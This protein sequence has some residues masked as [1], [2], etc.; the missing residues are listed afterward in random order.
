MEK[1][2][3]CFSLKT[4]QRILGGFLIISVAVFVCVG[5]FIQYQDLSET[6]RL[7][8]ETT[9]YIQAE[10]KKFDNYTRGSSAH[11]LQGML[12]TA[13]GLKKFI[14]EDKLADSS[15]LKDFIH[16]EHVGGIIV[17]DSN[18][19]VLAQADMDDQD[20]FAL[21]GETIATNGIGDI[22]QHPEETY[23]DNIAVN[24]MPYDV[25]ATASEDGSI[26][27]FCYS[28][29]AK[30]AYDPYE[31]TIKSVLTNNSFFK[32][33]TLIITDGT[34]ILSTNDT[35]IEEQGAEQYQ[36]MLSSIDW[37]ENQLTKFRYNNTT[38]Y[39]L[40]RVYNTYFAYT[41]Y[42]SENVFTSR[43]GFIT[44]GFSVYML[45]AIA[46]LAVQRHFDKMSMNK[47]EKQLRI[48]NAI[49]TAYSSTF[50]LHVDTMELE[51]V[52]PSDRLKA[53]FERKPKPY[54][55][56]FEICKNEVE[57]DYYSTV[58]HFLDLDTIAE[59]LRGKPFLG[60]EVKDRCG[61][62]YSVLLIPQKCDEAG[63]I[64]ALL[65][66]T[67]DVTSVKQTEELTFK[68]QLTGLYN[69]NYME[70][71]SKNF[72][73]AGDFPVS[74][75]MADCNYLKRTNDTLGHEYGDLLLQRIANAITETIP[76]DF[77]AMRV[78]GDEFLVLCTHCTA[79]RAQQTVAAIKQ[80]L[81]ERSDD[82]LTLSA[83]FGVSTTENGDE[84]SFDQAYEAADQEMY[85]DK[86]AS[87]IER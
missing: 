71:R 79:E 53:I 52:H 31:L 72:V 6:Y 74:L 46:I 5:V 34:N 20:S 87:R 70:S 56:L 33:P 12:D 35:A 4:M 73:R 85:R 47:M 58:M 3:K 26:L 49:S 24:E 76:D 16:T 18:R 39:G 11:T 37:K 62:W 28:S 21:W 57:E 40:R 43:T 80:K 8:K 29:T 64:Q 1:I 61:A 50:L 84:F 83:A 78:G 86:K 7:A 23:I 19:K 68:D 59:R 67:R 81:A 55:F 38:Y 60:C 45:I 75:I 2:K 17:L 82:K 15:F 32:D 30:P 22:L 36:Q 51:P 44:F 42:T 54:E 48:I 13:N 77:V 9:S 65:V 25:A 41:L 66:M 10:C 69:R 63:N 14:A 27:I